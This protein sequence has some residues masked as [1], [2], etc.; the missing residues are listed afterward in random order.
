MAFRFK[1]V[2]SIYLFALGVNIVCAASSAQIRSAEP[3][4]LTTVAPVVECST[5]VNA[6]ISSAVGAP[7]HITSATAV[8]A[9]QPA[10]YCDVKGTVEPQ[11][12]FELRLPLT[13]WTQ[14]F[15]QTGCGGLCGHIDMGL[16]NDDG[17]LPATNGELA[18]ASTDMGHSGGM[19]GRFGEKDY[20]LR[21]DFAYR[22]V[23]ITTLA[24]KALMV[25]FYGQQP[26]YSY[27][28][29][30]SDGGREALMEA[31]RFPN[32]FNGITAG[33]PAMNFTTQ[34]TFYHG[35]NAR[36]NTG[37]DGKPILTADKLPLLHKA[38]LAK[39]DAED[40]LKDGLISNPLACHF[41]PAVLECKAGAAPGTCLTSAQVK[42]VRELYAGAHDS[43]GNKLVLSGPLPGSE[44]A[45]AG[46]YIPEPGQDHVMSEM[47]STGTLKY[48]AYETNPP[49]GYTLADLKF[50]RANFT[51]T[52]KLHALYDATD[53][54]LTAFAASGGKLIL[55]HG[56]AD[57]HISPLN[58]IAYY[59][60]MQKTMGDEAVN[61]F[62]RLYLFPGGYHCGG[63]EGPFDMDM[64]SAIMAWVEQAKAPHALLAAHVA[65]E[66]HHGPPPGG[67][68]NGPP[69]EMAGGPPTRQAAKPDRTRP[70]Y[71][72]PMTAKYIGSGSIDD[73]SNFVEGN[74]QPAPT[75]LLN[76]LGASF[77]TPHYELWCT[78]SSAT[79]NCKPTP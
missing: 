43:D 20:Q 62:A 64:L 16:D 46:V 12:Q 25:K 29:G 45:W 11:I 15:V 36:V 50:E 77:Y 7:T 2:L 61:K 47:I 78:G 27:F 41:D 21:I 30:C 48:L 55:W 63:G 35:W 72:Y 32:D 54:D 52:T 74:P 10:P 76:W 59:T 79:M 28:A 17:C 13:K 69:P 49:T 70:V 75:E 44:L 19:D 23:H 22:G 33:A 14:R 26:T 37:A 8:P 9:G 65:R 38:V 40:G 1:T 68:Q 56:L 67:P 6:D 42:V 34:N 51:A 18:L 5:L 66:E 3:A 57:P 58:T 71:P 60:A 24:A 39:C 73:A 4:V 31:Q 53:P